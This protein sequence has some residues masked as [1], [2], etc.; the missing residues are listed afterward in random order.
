MCVC[1]FFCFAY[2]Y[3]HHH[4]TTAIIINLSLSIDII[5]IINNREIK[6]LV[7]HATTT[8][9]TRS[10]FFSSSKLHMND[11][12]ITLI[13][14]I[15]KKKRKKI[16]NFSFRVRIYWLIDWLINL[17]FCNCNKLVGICFEFLI[18]ICFLFIYFFHSNF[19]GIHW[20]IILDK[21][22][23]NNNSNNNNNYYKFFFAQK[24]MRSF[25]ERKKNKYYLFRCIEKLF[26]HLRNSHSFI[27]LKIIISI[28]IISAQR[29]S[30]FIYFFSIDQSKTH[31]QQHYVYEKKRLHKW[32]DEKA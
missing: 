19:T 8:T 23:P 17:I 18:I 14:L 20:L 13:Y 10:I 15:D 22:Y 3:H 16:L 31:K 1:V 24:S 6:F 12:L 11:W 28:S 26:R 21:W 7:L 4:I 27:H 9:T 5:I 32:N 25:S 2:H 30:E 29:I